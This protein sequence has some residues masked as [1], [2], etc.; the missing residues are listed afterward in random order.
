MKKVT[1]AWKYLTITSLILALFKILGLN[2]SWSLVIIP[3]MIM[4]IISV[5]VVVG[6]CLL[7]L[8]TALE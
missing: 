1:T 5:F 8:I 3:F 7:L 2:I 6:F 4:P